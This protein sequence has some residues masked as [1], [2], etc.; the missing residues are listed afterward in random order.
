LHWNLSSGKP[1]GNILEK[2]AIAAIVRYERE[3]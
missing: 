1:K 3:I 2:I